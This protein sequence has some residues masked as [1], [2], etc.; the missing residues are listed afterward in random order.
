MGRNACAKA[1]RLLI[2]PEV[3]AQRDWQRGDE[4]AAALRAA[5][6]A[7]GL[8]LERI[9]YR[10]GQRG[11]DISVATLSY[12]QSGRSRP[13]RAT[14]LAALGA[15]EEI[16][17]VPRGSL[18]VR[19]P[20]PRR[21]SSRQLRPDPV[22]LGS[23]YEQASL[24]DTM[25]AELGLSWTDGFDQVAVH[26]TIEI[27]ADRTVASHRVMALIR[28]ARDRLDRI[29]VGQ[30]EDDPHVQPYLI[31]ARNCR[32]GRMLEVPGVPAIVGELILDRPLRAG[33]AVA[34]E[35]YNM[36]VGQRKPSSWWGRGVL[37]QQRE[38]HV[39]LSFDPEAIPVSA[40][41]F[42]VLDGI[43]QVSPLVLAGNRLSLLEIDFGPGNFGVRWFW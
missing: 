18:A 23:L 24:M 7:R 32:V 10:L 43:E 6:A 31:A 4:F 33:E 41:C 8:A 35:Y 29:P 20:P 2:L 12:W 36:A 22:S 11:H 40:E 25:L 1:S 21:R 38:L 14:S 34:V 30:M 17:E 27:R 13:E 37:K 28:A 26:D 19:L 15:L 9:R 42:T 16:L 39:E 5:I 3:T